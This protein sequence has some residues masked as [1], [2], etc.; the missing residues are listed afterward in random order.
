MGTGFYGGFGLT[1][2]S[3]IIV[4][5]KLGLLSGHSKNYTREDLLN[6]IDGVTCESTEIAKAIREGKIKVNVLGDHLF[7]EYLG[8]SRD[9]VALAVGNQIY[10]R[11]SSISIYSDLVHEGIHAKDYL[12]GIK[13]E[14][15]S[16]V[17]GE[18][19]AY[20]AERRFQIAKGIHVEYENEEDMLVHIWMNYK[21]R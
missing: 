14:E 4:S 7:E 6:Y 18:I 20:S 17:S 21:R 9:T 10:I 16:S 19:R 2:G 13:E 11:N 8:V 12:S 5:F 15:I 3:G 1:S